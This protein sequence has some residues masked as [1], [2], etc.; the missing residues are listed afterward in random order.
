[1]AKFICSKKPKCIVV[2]AYWLESEAKSLTKH[3]KSRFD[4]KVK[5]PA[6]GIAVVHVCVPPFKTHIKIIILSLLSKQLEQ[7]STAKMTR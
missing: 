6:F 5:T 1:M 3:G 4:L 2:L 7:K